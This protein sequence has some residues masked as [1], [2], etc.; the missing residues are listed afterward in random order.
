MAIQEGEEAGLLS[1]LVFGRI[2]R[3]VQGWDLNARLDTDSS[4]WHC[5][6][7]SVQAVGGPTEISLIA[8]ATIDTLSRTG[9]L[10]QIGL[11]QPFAPPAVVGGWGSGEALVASRYNFVSRRPDFAIAYGKAD[12][13]VTVSVDAE[14]QSVTVRQRIDAN[15]EISPIFTSDGQVELEYVLRNGAGRG[16]VMTANYKPINAVTLQYNEL[17]WTAHAVIPID[18]YCNVQEGAKVNIRRSFE[19]P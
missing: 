14:K 17:S 1:F 16:G 8:R 15:R 13:T 11:E 9:E 3:R 18:G 5:I 4:D 6:D 12:T 2:H 19:S 7:A 10:T